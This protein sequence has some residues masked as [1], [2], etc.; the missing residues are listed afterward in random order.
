MKNIFL[1]I[2]LLL[3]LSACQKDDEGITPPIASNLNYSQLKVGNYWIYERYRL[4]TNGVETSLN[5]TDSSYI[6]KDTV[7]NSKTHYKLFRPDHGEKYVQ[8][9]YFLKDSA[10]SLVEPNGKV[11]FSSQNI[12]VSLNPVF[13]FL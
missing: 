5:I 7:I 9:V 3:I 1:P 6:E 8:E 12:G 10:T 13:Y 2:L 4:D 11:V